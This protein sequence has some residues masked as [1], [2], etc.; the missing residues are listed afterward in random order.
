MSCTSISSVPP[1]SNADSY[2]RHQELS[3]WQLN[4]DLSK[5]TEG[6]DFYCSRCR[7]ANLHST[8]TTAVVIGGGELL[9]KLLMCC[10]CSWSRRSVDLCWLQRFYLNYGE[11]GVSRTQRR[12]LSSQHEY[13]DYCSSQWMCLCV[14]VCVVVMRLGLPLLSSFIHSLL[15]SLIHHVLLSSFCFVASTVIYILPNMFLSWNVCG[16]TKHSDE[17]H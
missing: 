12:C 3:A 7:A 10:R 8:K 9:W 11:K 6:R 1:T 17:P 4:M 16:V 5:D 2:Q 13:Q 15:T 14:C